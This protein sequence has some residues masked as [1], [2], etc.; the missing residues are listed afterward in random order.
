MPLSKTRKF[1]EEMLPAALH[2]NQA[3]FNLRSGSICIAVQDE[4]AWTLRFGRYGSDDCFTEEL[5]EAADC[6]MLWQAQGFEK[7][8][9]EQPLCEQDEPQ[10]YGL[11]HMLG[12]FV[13]MLKEPARGQAALRCA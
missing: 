3:L 4:G 12:I 5:D 10:C 13:S 11:E 1:F 6:I 9:M 2:M 7:M 8:L